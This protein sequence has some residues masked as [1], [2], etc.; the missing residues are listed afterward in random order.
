MLKLYGSTTS[1]YVRRLR[2]WMARIEHQFVDLQIFT[3]EDREILTK[4]NPTMKIPMLE[5]DG[6]V[7][8]DSRVIFRYLSE[9]WQHSPLSWQAENRLTLIDAANDSLVQMFLLTRTDIDTKQDKLYFNLQRERVTGVLE[10]LNEQLD[11]GQFD[12]WHYES[13]CLFCL[14]DWIQFRNLYDFST[15]PALLQFHQEQLT[16]LEVIATD[17]RE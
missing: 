12:D 13:I 16:R 4:L 11:Q 14:L 15:L 17:P 5:D 10:H 3:P 7:I 8:F 1:P 9:K 2:I 6:Q